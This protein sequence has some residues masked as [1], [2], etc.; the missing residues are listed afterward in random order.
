MV[1]SFRRGFVHRPSRNVSRT[2]SGPLSSQGRAHPPAGASPP[3]PTSGATT[4]PDAL[5]PLA[6]AAKRNPTARRDALRGCVG[7]MVTSSL[8]IGALEPRD[9]SVPLRQST[10]KPF[11]APAAPATCAAQRGRQLSGLTGGARPGHDHRAPLG[12]NE[13]RRGVSGGRA[14]PALRAVRVIRG[15]RRSERFRAELDRLDRQLSSRTADPNFDARQAV[16]ADHHQDA[17]RTTTR[18]VIYRAGRR[19]AVRHH[20]ESVLSFPPCPRRAH[21]D[22]QSLD[23]PTCEHNVL[24]HAARRMGSAPPGRTGATG[25]SRQSRQLDVASSARTASSGSGH[26]SD[27]GPPSVASLNV[28]AHYSPRAPP[29]PTT[30]TARPRRA[31]SL[32]QPNERPS[33]LLPRLSPKTSNFPVG[34]KVGARLGPGPA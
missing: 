30:A 21:A 34:T 17:I 23:A 3:S 2:P 10:R 27:D 32:T 4:H 20:D 7:S 12:F 18:I 6:P 16:L 29:A 19:D 28:G 15:V 33:W 22:S 25:G 31:R 13:R 9:L 11:R 8:E 26:P 1:A 24:P 5:A 14:R